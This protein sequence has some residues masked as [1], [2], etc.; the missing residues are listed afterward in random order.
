MEILAFEQVQFIRQQKA[1]LQEIDWRIEAG[2]DWAVLGLNGAG[3]SLMLNMISGNL[4]PSSGKLTVL[5]EVFGRTSIPD[6]TKRIGWVSQLVFIK[7][8]Q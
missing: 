1:L 6:L 4:W 5:G 7:N 2:E 3:K 8:T